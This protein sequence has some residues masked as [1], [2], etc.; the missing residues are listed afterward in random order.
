M[1]VNICNLEGQ[2]GVC[3]DGAT[4]SSNSNGQEIADIRTV[5]E[6]KEVRVGASRKLNLQHLDI[7]DI[8]SCCEEVEKRCYVIRSQ[9]TTAKLATHS[10]YC[11]QD[12]SIR[13]TKILQF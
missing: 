3:A 8:D 1:K 6:S 4:L 9:V 11:L 13:M 7:T 10:G 2:E 5:V 12:L